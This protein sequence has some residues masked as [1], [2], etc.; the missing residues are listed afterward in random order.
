MINESFCGG[1]DS[2][3]GRD[4]VWRIDQRGGSI[5]IV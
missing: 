5:V 1:R 4:F 2:R 3:F